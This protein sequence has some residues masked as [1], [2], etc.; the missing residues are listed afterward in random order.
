[1]LCSRVDGI[2]SVLHR[3]ALGCRRSRRTTHASW[4]NPARPRA[5]RRCLLLGASTARTPRSLLPCRCALLRQ[6]KQSAAQGSVC[7]LEDFG[8]NGALCLQSG[9]SHDRTLTN[10]AQTIGHVR[11]RDGE[12]A[13]VRLGGHEP[14][15]GGALPERL[16]DFRPCQVWHCFPPPSDIHKVLVRPWPAPHSLF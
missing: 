15:G 3:S 12:A 5:C 14:A 9:A 7:L 6:C 8:C 1:M 16:P 4:Q 11:G 10:H 13:H 2:V